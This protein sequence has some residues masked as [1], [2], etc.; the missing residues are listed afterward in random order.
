MSLYKS[1]A[2][3]ELVIPVTIL[4][5]AGLMLASANKNWPAVA[6]IFMAMLFV[7]HVFLTTYYEVQGNLLK[8]KCGF[9]I[10][11]EVDIRQ[12]VSIRETYNPLS[13]PATSLDRLELKLTGKDSV[14]VSPKDKKGFIANLLK[15]KPEIKVILRKR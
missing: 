13:A 7:L 6:V 10:D 3:P 8:V 4:M 9:L 12:I 5:F 11:K 2:G 1:K 15:V 14:L